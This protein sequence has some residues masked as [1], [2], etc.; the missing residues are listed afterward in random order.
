MEFVKVTGTSFVR[1]THSMGLSNVDQ[2]EKN[3]YYTKVRLIKNQKELL[4]KANEEICQLKQ[5]M[6]EIKSL[7]AQ[8]VNKQ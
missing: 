6:C 7:L 5:D 3:E 2:N 4:N 1:D 8:L